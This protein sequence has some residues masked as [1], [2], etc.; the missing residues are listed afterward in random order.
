MNNKIITI[1]GAT[2]FVGKYVCADL[3][4]AGY[5]IRVVSRSLERAKALRTGAFV[6]QIV[7]VAGDINNPESFAKLVEGSYGVVNLVGILYQS[8]RQKFENMHNINAG[9]LATAAKNAGAEV[10]VHVSANIAEDSKAKYAAS[11]IAGERAVTSVFPE[12]IILKPSIIFGAEDN[13]FNKFARMG[14]LSPLFPLIGGGRTKFQPVYVA[15]VSKAILAGVDS[16]NVKPG[17]YQLGGPQ[18]LTFKELLTRIDEYTGRKHAF[19]NLPFCIANIM[20]FFSP[21]FILTRDQ[22]ELL[23]S[24]NTISSRSKGLKELGISPTGIE[25]VVPEYL[26]RYRKQTHPDHARH[27]V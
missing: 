3:V 11:K 5:T 13:F 15:D 16:E 10:F 25:A 1:F 27:S 24:D 18:V 2:G 26:A 14:V 8:G 4:K 23:K 20:A 22:V 6:G 9:K 17:N 19:I 7:P 12:A 21:S